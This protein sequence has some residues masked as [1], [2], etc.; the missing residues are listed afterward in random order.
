MSAMIE[1]LEPSAFVPPQYASPPPLFSKA[2]K[3]NRNIAIIV[4]LACFGVIILILIVHALSYNRN[5][6]HES[7]VT[8]DQAPIG[9]VP[10]PIGSNNA[11][12]T[13]TALNYGAAESNSG[14]LEPYPTTPLPSGVRTLQGGISLAEVAA[15]IGYQ[16][17][18]GQAASYYRDQIRAGVEAF[19]PN[20]R[21]TTYDKATIDSMASILSNK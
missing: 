2:P 18:K 9:E 6:V 21:L 5:D 14:P 7:V 19:D 13:M 10:P 8:S 3:P 11:P 12:E 4:G 20:Y 15:M 16:L 1:D 17:P